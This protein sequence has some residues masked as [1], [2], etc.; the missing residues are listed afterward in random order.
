[1]TMSECPPEEDEIAATHIGGVL[2]TGAVIPYRGH[3]QI[4]IPGPEAVFTAVHIPWKG[5]PSPVAVRRLL[6]ASRPWVVALEIVCEA[7][8]FIVVHDPEPG[9][10]T[11][12]GLELNGRAAVATFDGER[13]QS[14]CLAGG[15]AARCGAVEVMADAGGNGFWEA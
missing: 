6:P 1:M 5:T 9:I 13:I 2:K 7:E 8:T 15:T 14:L 4:A 12:R 11:V 3:L 10:S